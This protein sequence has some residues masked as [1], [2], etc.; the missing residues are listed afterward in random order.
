MSHGKALISTQDPYMYECVSLIIHCRSVHKLVFCFS[1]AGAYTLFPGSR[2]KHYGC[3]LRNYKWNLLQ[4]GKPGPM[5]FSLK[6]ILIQY[7]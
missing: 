4:T 3:K 6:M 5:I 2:L 1:V 7:F